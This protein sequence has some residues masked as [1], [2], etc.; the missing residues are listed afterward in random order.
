MQTNCYITTV[1]MTLAM[2]GKGILEQNG[3]GARVSRLPQNLTTAGCAWGISID[4]ANAGR[5]KDALVRAGFAYGKMVYADGSPVLHK[6]V[7][8]VTGTPRTTVPA[9]RGGR[10]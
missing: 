4:S 5:A 9:K 8:A 2:K 6:S 10:T 7:T 1:T 3:I